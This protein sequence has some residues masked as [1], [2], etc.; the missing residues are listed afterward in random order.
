MTYQVPLPD[1]NAASQFFTLFDA[2]DMS[3]ILVRI[4]GT[5]D[6]APVLE[7]G[8]AKYLE[9]HPI[10]DFDLK[11]LK[12]Q[13]TSRVSPS[14]SNEVLEHPT[15]EGFL[16]DHVYA[17]LNAIEIEATLYEGRVERLKKLNELRTSKTLLTLVCDMD[18][19]KNYIIS[20]IKP[21]M[22]S[23]SANAFDVS[24]TFQEVRRVEL[25]SPQI[26]TYT[27]DG[28]EHGNDTKN[29]GS[30]TLT[31]KSTVVPEEKESYWGTVVD[32]FLFFTA[33]LPF[34]MFGV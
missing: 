5:L 8:R 31:L 26:T 18:V 34:R 29:L 3:R 7:G 12:P 27:D 9:F 4:P 25:I 22:H 30:V 16:L 32:G 23:G 10:A 20:D 6:L 28:E 14:L 21:A 19:Y 24:I 11:P 13:L 33:E 17:K 1:P 15:Q 2:E